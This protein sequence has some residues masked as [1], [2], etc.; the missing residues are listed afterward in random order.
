VLRDIIIVV[1][2]RICNGVRSNIGVMGKEA[3]SGF[4]EG[5]GHG[6]RLTR[7]TFSNGGEWAARKASANE[8]SVRLR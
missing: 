8:P 7:M 3:L 2:G 4:A 5:V 1:V 6:G